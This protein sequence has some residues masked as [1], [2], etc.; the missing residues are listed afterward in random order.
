MKR[1]ASLAL[2]LMLIFSVL[3]MP[4][5]ALSGS[6]KQTVSTTM[7]LGLNGGQSGQSNVITFSFTGSAIPDNA[8]ITKVNVVTGT[9]TASG[10]AIATTALKVKGP[11]MSNWDTADWRNI[12]SGTDFKGSV[13]GKQAKGTWQLA[14]DGLNASS[15]TYGYKS[16]VGATMTIEYTY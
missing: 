7:S 5:S 9:L 11:G 8:V 15:T 2:A 16:H 3:C 14:F 10:G 4:V 12:S 13:V 1:T 6:A